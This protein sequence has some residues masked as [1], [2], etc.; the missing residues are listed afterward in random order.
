MTALRSRI[1]LCTFDITNTLLKFKT[2]VGEQYAKVGRMYGVEREPS[3]IS[4]SFSQHWNT[5]TSSYPNFGCNDGLTSREWWRKIIQKTF[6]VDGKNLTSKELDGI[7]NHL[8][9]IYETNICWDL[10][11]GALQLLKN[12]RAK[13][14]TLGVISNFD[15]RLESLLCAYD[16]KSFFHFVLASYVVHVGKPD[17][18]IFDLALTNSPGVLSLDALH[19]GD[20][21]RLDYQAAKNAGW[22]AL[23]ICDKD[24]KMNLPKDINVTEVI[25]NITEVES[26][27]F[28]I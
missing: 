14:I 13:N 25:E 6:S 8:F 23:L 2:S 9:Y 1:K 15:E 18:S 19:V 11:P 10:V 16:M 3:Q 22:R 7:S 21:L 24:K 4:S 5:M 12:L 26:H 20:N 17:R 28:C 27:L